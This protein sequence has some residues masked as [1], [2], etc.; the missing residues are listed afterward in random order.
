MLLL[1]FKNPKRKS[2]ENTF[3]NKSSD[4]QSRTAK[5]NVINNHGKP[6]TS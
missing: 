4:Q 2:L 5:S 1:R 6:K 3:A